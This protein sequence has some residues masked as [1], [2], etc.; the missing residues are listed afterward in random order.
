MTRPKIVIKSKSDLSAE[1]SISKEND[2]SQANIE[3]NISNEISDQSESIINAPNNKLNFKFIY[4]GAISLCALL[5]ISGLLYFFLWRETNPES[6]SEFS[7]NQEEIVNDTENPNEENNLDIIYIN[8]YEK[9]YEDY[10]KDILSEKMD[11]TDLLEKIGIAGAD[12]SV[13]RKSA[14]KRD[15]R[16]LSKG[17]KYAIYYNEDIPKLIVIEQKVNPYIKYE[18]YLEDLSFIQVKKVRQVKT[19]ELAGIVESNLGLTFINNNFNLKLINRLEEIFEY[20]VDLFQVDDG[21]RF[22]ILYEQEFLDG[23]PHEIL[24]IKAAYMREGNRDY[25]AFMNKTGN[26]VEYFNEFGESMKRSFLSSPIKYGGNI[27]SG[28]GLR[29]HPK[30][31]FEKMHL[32]TD[33]AAPEGT[34]I[35]ATADGTMTIIGATAN[36]GNYVKMK[37][38]DKFETQYLHLQKFNPDLTV[39]SRVRQGDIIGYVGMTGSATGPHVCYRFWKNGEQVDPKENMG[40]ITNRIPSQNMSKYSDYIKPLASSLKRIEYF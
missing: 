7:E 27:S 15:V 32:G 34:P 36:N 37:H 12:I 33:Y 14:D 17:D 30:Y 2:S 21:D 23:R 26:T 39:G 28:F 10:V 24:K 38:D 5:L 13:L 29:I 25:Y 31:G 40:N 19:M 1:T 6:E 3:D 9:K 20:S 11:F 16:T 22:K 4:L 8:D 18:I 35:V